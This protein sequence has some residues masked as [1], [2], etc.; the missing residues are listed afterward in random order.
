MTRRGRI[1]SFLLL[2]CV[3][4]GCDSASPTMA[5]PLPPPGASTPPSSPVPSNPNSISVGGY[6]YDVAWRPLT[7]A[8]IEVLDGPQA[9]ASAISDSRGNF[10]LNGEFNET[11]RFRASLP[12]HR[13]Q[14]T[15][16]Q[17]R[18]PACQPN[19]WLSFTLET[20]APHADLSGQ[21]QLT[22]VA[23]E[24]CTGLPSELRQRTYSA[25]VS[26]GSG[27][28]RFVVSLQGGTFIFRYDRFD[29]GLAGDTF[30]AVLGDFHGTPGIAERVSGD[31]YLGFEGQ[32]TA[33]VS[34]T[35][36]T[37]INAQFEGVISYCEVAGPVPERFTCPANGP[38][39]R[40]QC[41]SDRHQMILQR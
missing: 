6:I 22:F 1:V 7:G 13:D 11:T 4:A 14:T 30:V 23:A 38:G 24:H 26:P 28:G 15:I 9:G 36:V 20:D 2:V 37:E 39:E 12:G 35:A 41:T 25:S 16:L 17:P 32:A 8:R 29:V 18:C 40:V 10:Y 27:A 5:T 3:A 19:W 31:G 21:Y 34:A 33:Q